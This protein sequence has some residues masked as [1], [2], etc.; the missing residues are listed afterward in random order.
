[1]GRC[2]CVCWGVCSLAGAG[3]GG[4]ERG[5]GR[6]WKGKSAPP[7][8]DGH[9]PTWEGLVGKELPEDDSGGQC[10]GQVPTDEAAAPQRGDT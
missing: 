3:A 1:M 8:G 4:E 5:K 9:G 10:L 2:V 6:W 7:R